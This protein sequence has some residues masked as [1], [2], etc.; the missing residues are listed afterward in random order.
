MFVNIQ[1]FWRSQKMTKKSQN[2]NLKFAKNVIVVCQTTH[3]LLQ[4][5]INRGFL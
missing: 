1:Y 3:D 5:E 4:T 2:L